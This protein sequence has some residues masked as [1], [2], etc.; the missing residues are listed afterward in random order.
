MRLF[1]LTVGRNEASRYLVPMLQHTGGIVDKHFFFDDQST[2]QT[3]YLV[4]EYSQ[5]Y[6]VRRSDNEASFEENEGALRGAAWHSFESFC[7]PQ[8]GDW[9][10][11]IDC[12]EVLVSWTTEDPATVR[13]HIEDEIRITFRVAIDLNIPEVFGFSGTGVPLV[14]SDG[15][16]GRIHAPR[17]FSYLPGGSYPSGK[18]G[19]PAVPDYVM[20]AIGAW[21]QTERLDL[22][23]YGYA[24]QRDQQI[25]YER[26]NGQHGH[27]NAHVQ[28]I[29][30]EDKVLESWVRP[31]VEGMREAWAQST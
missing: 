28:S 13:Q 22:M 6:L 21:S 23:H 9:V 18:V 7:N 24:R 19:A 17:L 26:Y 30:T 25:K 11:V 10:L 1:A 20:S 5:A 2:D 16:W 14:R 15:E 27:G 8:P 12:D 3:P 29:I 4:A 31:Y